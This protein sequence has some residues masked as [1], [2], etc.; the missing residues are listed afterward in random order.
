[1]PQKINDHSSWVG[2][3]GKGSV[4]PMG[5]KMKEESPAGGAGELTKYE[6]T[7]EAIKSM[8]NEN[9]RKA[10]ANSAKAEYRN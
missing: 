9:M 8:Q 2:K 10:K 5:T 7:S 3:G 4:F 6:D 1:M